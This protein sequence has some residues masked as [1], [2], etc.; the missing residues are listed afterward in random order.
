MKSA[1]FFRIVFF[2]SKNGIFI[3]FEGGEGCGKTSQIN[4]LAEFMRK[5]GRECVIT[6]EPGGTAVSEKIRELLL[7]AKEGGSMSAKLKCCFLT[8][9][10]R[11]M[12]TS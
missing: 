10:A 3:T 8:Q 6:R 5:K 4:L 7:H 12:S 1:G 9:R 11:S 2:I